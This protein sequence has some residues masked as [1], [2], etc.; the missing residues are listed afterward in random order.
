MLTA[1]V[2]I[3]TNTHVKLLL[4][5]TVTLSVSCGAAAFSQLP[6]EVASLVASSAQPHEGVTSPPPSSSSSSSL[7]GFHDAFRARAALQPLPD[8]VTQPRLLL[9]PS[10]PLT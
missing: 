1:G 5:H 4:L 2:Y 3:Y 7:T 6:E 9:F 10:S 8:S